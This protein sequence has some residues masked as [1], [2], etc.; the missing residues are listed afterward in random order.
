MPRPIRTG[1]SNMVYTGPPG[2]HD[3]HCQRIRPGLVRTVWH[4]TPA[5]R[6]AVARGATLALEI[7]S[8]PIPPVGMAVGWEQGIGEDAPE[9]LNR[10][11]QLREAAD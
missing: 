4:F 6:E 9:T 5:E 10:L 7:F 3:L 1:D 2:V 11:E 8:E